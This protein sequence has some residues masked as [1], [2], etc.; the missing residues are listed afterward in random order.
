MVEVVEKS[1]TGPNYIADQQPKLLVRSLQKT[2]GGL[3]GIPPRDCLYFLDSCLEQT[4]RVLAMSAPIAHTCSRLLRSLQ[5]QA[6][7]PVSALLPLF[8]LILYTLL[9]ALLFSELEG[10][11]E[12]YELEVL[13]K[14]RNELFEVG[15]SSFRIPAASIK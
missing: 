6:K 5:N 2:L 1:A 8:G 10:P 9:G 13:K 11:N 4:F 7:A 14:Q 15:Q 12:Q 3:L